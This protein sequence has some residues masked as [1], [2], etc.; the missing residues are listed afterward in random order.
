MPTPEEIVRDSS[1]TTPQKAELLRR[2]AYD[3]ADQAVALEEGM[4]GDDSDLT[5]RILLALQELGQD[6]DVE[7]G[8]PTKQHGLR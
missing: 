1:L 5:R 3:E 8:G 4:P 2:M 7:R 6:A